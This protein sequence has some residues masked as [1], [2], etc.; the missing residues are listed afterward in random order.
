ML[1][2]SLHLFVDDHPEVML[3]ATA[4]FQVCDQPSA[5]AW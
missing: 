3:H 1:D 4:A 5:R 2:P